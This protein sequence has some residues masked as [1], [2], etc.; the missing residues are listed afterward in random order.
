MLAALRA[1]GSPE[2]KVRSGDPKME[3]AGPLKTDQS[4]YIVDAPFPTLL[5]PS[6][7]E[8]SADGKGH[9]GKWEVE[10]LAKEIKLIEGVLS[11]GLFVGFNGEE[12]AQKG[13][14]KG[15][16]KPVAAYFGMQ[17]GNVVIRTSTKK[18]EKMTSEEAK[19]TA[20][21]KADF[22]A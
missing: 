3:K 20:E 4:N 1:L 2:P 9:D 5:L 19:E 12:A 17:D 13:L 14:K 7:I 10:A 21:K 16:Q 18:E 15:G 6:D 22:K 8:G 11:V